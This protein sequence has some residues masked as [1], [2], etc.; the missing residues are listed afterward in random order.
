M[1]ELKDR[2]YPIIIS[3]SFE[4]ITGY[5]GNKRNQCVIITDSNVAE[6]HLESLK[7]AIANTYETIY[8]YTV[9]AGEESKSLEVAKQ[10]YQFMIEHNICREDAILTLGGGVIGDLGG[11]VAATFLRGIQYIQVPT[12]LLAQV[13]SSVGGK[14]AVNMNQIKNIIGAF[15]QPSLVYINQSVLKTLPIEEI[16]NGL[17]EVLVHGIILDADLFSYIEQNLEKIYSLDESVM[18]RVISWNCDIKKGVV[19]RDEKDLQERAI[20]NFGHTFGHA[21]EGAYEYTYRHGECVGVGIIG[22][23]YIA[24]KLGLIDGVITKRIKNLLI[25]MRVLPQISDCNKQKILDFLMHDK[26]KSDHDIYFILPLKIG[27]VKKYKMQD[28]KL[29]EDIL[30][31]LVNEKWENS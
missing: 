9:P 11:F 15:Y 10:L 31:V 27:Q 4:K 22:A 6:F 20:L 21:I 8:A 16:K 7:S 29:I 24:E 18:E 30:D 17:V 28:V 1:V 26:K 2:S 13:D 12:S 23:C 3:E 5:I 14:T 25:R 19:Q